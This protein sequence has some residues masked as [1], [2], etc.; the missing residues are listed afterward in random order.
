MPDRVLVLSAADIR[1]VCD[2]ASLVPVI[3][4][5]MR[6]V[7]AGEATL[8]I[9]SVMPLPGGNRFGMMAGRLARPDI[10]GIK[11]ISLFPENPARGRSSHA[12]LMVVFDA[13]TGLARACLD[14]SVLTLLRTAAASAVATDA[15]A[16]LDATR[17]AII[18]TGE[19]APAH[20][21]AMR[22]V[23]EIRDIV[24]YGRTREKADAVARACGGR[25]VGS[26]EDALSGAEIVCTVTAA[27]EPFLSPEMLAE[28][29]HLNAVGGSV[30]AYRELQPECI[31]AWRTV[32]DYR[33]ALEAG[34]WDVMEARARGLIPGDREIPEI[35]EVLAGSAAGRRDP[36]E[37]TLYR[38]LGIAA[39][40][41]AA[42][43]FIVARA[44]A[45]GVGT[46]VPI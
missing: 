19:Q 44:A 13:E 32:T 30:P 22:A 27:H 26:L 35:G 21:D 11:L 31:A 1:A 39:Q 16:R 17:L 6:A 3:A 23:R 12:G 14:A 36:R 20:I 25:A 34:A 9:R 10:Y 4:D 5:A 33:P 45:A 18:G 2:I 7:S 40:D 28:G 41:L 37:R 24:V 46:D 42:A 15:L 38:S 43:D 8:P 29:S